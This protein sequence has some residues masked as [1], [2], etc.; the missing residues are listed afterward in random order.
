MVL[1]L[2]PLEVWQDILLLSDF[3][4]QIRLRQVCKRF[5]Q[6][7]IHDFYSID[8]KYTKKLSDTILENYPFI[9]SLNVHDNLNVTNLNYMT[10]LQILVVSGPNCVIADEGIKNL[11]LIEL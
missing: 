2:L 5:L 10:K 4:S 9:R 3:L 11:N 8:S 1:P 7:E 6:L